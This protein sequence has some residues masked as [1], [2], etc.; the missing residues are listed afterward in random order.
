MKGVLT[1]LVDEETIAQLRALMRK[2][3][4]ERASVEIIKTLINE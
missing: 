3:L 4:N 1:A 2:P